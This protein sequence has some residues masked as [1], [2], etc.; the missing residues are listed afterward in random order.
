VYDLQA[1]MQAADPPERGHPE[2]AATDEDDHRSSPDVDDARVR[3][4]ADGP[5][6]APVTDEA[7]RL[8]AID[9]VRRTLERDWV[10][11]GLESSLEGLL[12]LLSSQL[13][14]VDLRALLW[15]EPLGLGQGS[16]RAWRVLHDERA[17]DAAFRRSLESSAQDTVTFEG[18][19]WT[20]LR[21]GDEVVGA[22]GSSRPLEPDARQSVARA[23]EALL[24]AHRRSQQRVYS[25][26]LTGLHNRRFFESQLG[27]E[28][29]R[30]Q[31]MGQPLGLL[32]V[33]LDHFKR[34]NDERGHETGDLVLQHVARLMMQHL[35]RIDQVFRWGGEEFALIL[36]GTGRNDALHT[37]ER[38]R[39]V[40][41]TTPLVLPGGQR[42]PSTVSVGVALAPEHAQ[43]G[44][45]A[46]LRHADQALYHAKHT[47]RNRVSLYGEQERAQAG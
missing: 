9:A 18:R 33:D 31:R 16:G 41:E 25:D 30:A 17:L 34:I 12:D 28:L 36:P 6:L 8:D 47:G 10:S 37:A 15:S 20:A 46:L 21:V 44:E 29:E 3:S 2:R 24:T 32:F 5:N 42:V 43:G 22:V 14:D 35:R 45:R 23:L 27:L 40:I 39:T 7:P 38:L 13:G 4:R 19:R 11:F 26:P 1:L